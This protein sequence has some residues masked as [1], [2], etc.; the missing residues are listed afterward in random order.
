MSDPRMTCCLTFDFD[1]MSVWIGSYRSTNPSEISRGEFGGVAIPRILDLLALRDVP[2]TFCIP[3]HTAYAYPDLVKRIHDAG[4][5]IAHHG[6][7][8]ENPADFDEAGERANMERGFEALEKACGVRP[9]GYRSPA[10][11]FSERTTD[12]LQEFGFLY[13]SSLMGDDYTPYYMRSGDKAPADA[14]YEFGKNINIVELPVTWTLDDFPY[15]ELDDTGSGLKPASHVEEIW[16]DEFTFA[17]TSVPGGM[18]NLTMHPQV[19]GRGHRLMM[20]ERLIDFMSGHADVKFDTL[21]GYAKRWA[22]ANPLQSWLTSG[23]IHAHSA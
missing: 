10:W 8:H 11:D 9:L 18:Y 17:H 1:A 7:V 23:S 2:G 13:D 3:G 5:E 4:H 20:L 22:D 16:R 12:I 21:G 6:W 14:R 19:I 15:F